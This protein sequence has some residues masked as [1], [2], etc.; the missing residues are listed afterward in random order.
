VELDYGEDDDGIEEVEMEPPPGG[1]ES[2]VAAVSSGPAEPGPDERP[3][4]RPAMGPATGPASANE[5]SCAADEDG[6]RQP[7]PPAR[8]VGPAMP[9]P[10]LL[11]AAQEAALAVSAS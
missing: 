7:A 9:P 3:S 5:P 6:A 10:E 2:G 4:I 8:P 1:G 11:A